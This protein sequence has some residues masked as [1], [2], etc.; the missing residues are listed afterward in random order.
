[1]PIPT[2][3]QKSDLEIV[4]IRHHFNNPS[5]LFLHSSRLMRAIGL[6]ANPGQTIAN[7]MK[8][9]GETTIKMAQDYVYPT[10]PLDIS[11]AK[12]AL[13]LLNG[14][15]GD[16]QSL[17]NK[18]FMAARDK[19]AMEFALAETPVCWAFTLDFGKNYFFPKINNDAPVTG[20]IR[21]FFTPNRTVY[22][23][24]LPNKWLPDVKDPYEFHV[25]GK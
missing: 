8:Q 21:G 14:L 1:M 17:F 7:A 15:H 4:V 18:V 24:A 12:D 10:K 25:V 16:L 2:I 20:G 13:E 23:N 3:F 6:N 11:S 5:Y 19:N 9:I 22:I